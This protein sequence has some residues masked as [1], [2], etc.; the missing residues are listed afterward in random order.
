MLEGVCE[1]GEVMYI[2]SRW[3]HS[4]MNLEQSIALTQNFVATYNLPN[5]LRFLR[6]KPD[7]ISGFS[8]KEG[9][10][11][12]F[13]KVLRTSGVLEGVDPALLESKMEKSSKWD[14]LSTGGDFS[15][16]F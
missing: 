13:V 11:E 2:P 9:V 14:A 5:V 10:F 15:F 12:D 3:W 4:V 7:Q 6:D 8:G 1:E 16:S